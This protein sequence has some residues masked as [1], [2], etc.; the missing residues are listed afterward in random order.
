MRERR[1]QLF[2]CVLIPLA[3]LA[4]M[5]AA[6]AFTGQWPWKGNPYNSYVLQACSWLEGR[7]DLGRD[8]PWLELAIHEGKYYVSFPPFP[9]YVLLPF[10]A[11][12]GTAAPDGWIAVVCSLLGMAAAVRLAQKCRPACRWAVCLV[13]AL[14]LSTGW[15]F[16]G[17]NGYVW[18]IAQSMCF[19]LSMGALLAAAS[20]RG[21]WALGLWACAVG[22]RPMAA[23]WLPVPALLLWEQAGRRDRSRGFFRWA[24]RRWYWAVP[25]L[26]IGGSYM[27]LNTLRFGNPLEFGHNYLPEFTRTATGQFNLSYMA[28]HIGELLRL[29]GLDAEGRFS[30]PT[31]EGVAFWLVNPLFLTVTAAWAAALIRR[32][33]GNRL[34]LVLVPA[35]AL[36]HAAVILLH[37]T[38]GGWQFGNRYL[39]DLMPWLYWALLR[40]MPDDRRF[41]L[42]NL[43]LAAW[44]AAVNLIGTVVTYNH[45]M[46]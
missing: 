22:C 24:L 19:A 8:Y 25:P 13:P 12:F 11:V 26:V 30:F 40:W 14:Y 42:A 21:G 9:S 39:V 17:L 29:P 45:W 5:A 36:A 31:A 38:L 6:M 18:F 43:P 37:R 41:A 23:F 1:E 32:R 10:A 28:G 16:I 35:L 20:G 2:A 7:L 44:G 46:P 34:T 15:L 3:L 27:L 33:E 4:V